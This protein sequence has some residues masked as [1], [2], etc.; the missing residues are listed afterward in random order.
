MSRLIFVLLVL[1]V[2]ASD[3]ISRE[4]IASPATMIGQAAAAQQDEETPVA[5]PAP[6][7]KALRYYRSGNVLWIVN[8]LWGLLVPAAFLFSGFS[9][10]IR[11]WSR[12]LGRTWFFVMVMYFAIFLSVHFVISLPLSYY[13]EFVRQHA[14][15]LSNQTFWK[16]LA[17]SFKD[18]L[19]GIVDGF[20]FL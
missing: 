15:G 5:V 19:V 11:N 10:R 12:R 16:W 17:D 20:L 13:E 3:R 9:A 8:L 6:G 1:I 7:E 4:A 14:Y 18:L 2:P